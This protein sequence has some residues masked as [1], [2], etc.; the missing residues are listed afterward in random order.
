MAV[1]VRRLRG[2]ATPYASGHFLV[3][4]GWNRQKRR[5]VCLDPAFGSN[6]LVLKAYRLQDFLR[7]WHRS[8][9]LA[10]VPMPR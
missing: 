3:V 1:S 4:V 8:M 5:V 10:Y 2:G 6:R 7:A 9:N